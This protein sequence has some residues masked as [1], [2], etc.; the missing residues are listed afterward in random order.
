MEGREMMVEK[1]T[2][3]SLCVAM[4]VRDAEQ[5]VAQ[6]LDNIQ[7]IADH[8]VIVD[9]GSQD[10]TIA[11]AEARGAQVSTFEWQDDFS[12]ARN[13]CLA[14]TTGDWVLWLDAGETLQ[15]REATAI[16]DF[17]NTQADSNKAYML[18]IKQPRC[19]SDIAAE[20]VGR[21]RL[22]PRREEISFVGRIRESM[23]A[24][25]ENANIEIDGLP[26][27]IHRPACDAD[28]NVKALKAHRNLIL[29]ER[30]ARE[31]G[32]QPRLLNCLGDALQNIGQGARAA[33]CFRESLAISQAGSTEMLEAYYGLLTSL[34][35]E[36][37]A[38]A[39]QL[40][41]CVEAVEAYPLDAQLLCA[42]G[43]YLQAQGRIDLACRSYQTSCQYGQVNPQ[44]WH[45]ENIAEVAA[46]CYCLSLQVQEKDDEALDGL[47]QALEQHPASLRLRRQ[48]MDL[49]VKLGRKDDA[50][51]QLA[52]FPPDTPHREVLK[53]AVRGACL[54]AEKN[55]ISAVA[56]LRAA[57]AAGCRDPLCLRWL[58]ISLVAT[59]EVD[60]AREVVLQ[61]QEVDP[62]NPEIPALKQSLGLQI[63]ATAASRVRI[64]GAKITADAEMPHL[65][66]PATIPMSNSDSSV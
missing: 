25:L 44:V 38:A 62:S 54:A 66:S 6:T 20:Q 27:I 34:E 42:M 65:D 2:S 28:P 35:T 55:W 13:H 36:V 40:S 11:V 58:T 47:Q 45:L 57:H 43:G 17:V 37:N 29:G 59:E 18:L 4:I 31:V 5:L 32:A 56:Y 1:K 39:V 24:S 23:T 16:R 7:P 33:Q 61:W 15:Q 48:L 12:S 14:Q 8:I 26:W 10:D 46:S 21:V 9:T 64:D 63:P 51:A 22:V 52:L 30:E 19:Q 50:L 60:Q 49:Y 53:S 41:V 3:R